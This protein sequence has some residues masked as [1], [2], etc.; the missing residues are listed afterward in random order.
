MFE[1]VYA[2]DIALHRLEAASKHGAIALP[3]EELK[4]RL[5]GD[6]GGR[7]ADAVLEVVGHGSALLTAL[8]LVRPF[9]VV[10]SCGVHTHDVTI[11]GATLYAKKWVGLCAVT[12]R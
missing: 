4:T 5:A 11:N 10:S 12:L 2:T 7:G 6:S 8:D 9:G 1:K 3:L